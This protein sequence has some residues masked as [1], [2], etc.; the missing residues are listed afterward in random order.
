MEEI[1]NVNLSG[2]E[3]LIREIVSLKNR[4]FKQKHHMA[5]VVDNNDPDKLG[6][7]KIRVRNMMESLLDDDLPWALPNQSFVGSL[8]G[9]FIVP[10]VGALVNVYFRNNDLNCPEYTTMVVDSNN[11]P[12]ERLEDYPDT[13]V[14]MKTDDGTYVSYNRKTSE[15][16]FRHSAGLM[17][18]I[19]KN[20]D[21]I[22]DSKYSMIGKMNI[23]CLGQV[24]LNAPIINFP[25]GMVIPNPNGGPFQAMKVDPLTGLPSSGNF[26]YRQGL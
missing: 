3:D 23:T 14:L 7:C 9:N 21:V 13:L 8:E 1:K 26:H 5:I 12:D 20:G 24:T 22:F 18:T 10:P 25:Q 4:E 6:K 17:I 19:D 2:L 11:L 16:V 15:F